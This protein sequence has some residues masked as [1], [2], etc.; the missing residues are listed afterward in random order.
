MPAST[1]KLAVRALLVLV[2]MSIGG[3]ITYV[4]RLPT[5]ADTGVTPGAVFITSTAFGFAKPRNAWL[6][7]LAIGAWIPAIAI[8]RDGNVES[9]LA[10]VVASAGA[11]FGA[12]LRILSH[13][14]RWSAK[15]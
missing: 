14:S 13:G 4:D 11:Y 10:L 8:T 9:L 12:F 2:A 6:W 5:W 1:S 3:A 7:A 15:G